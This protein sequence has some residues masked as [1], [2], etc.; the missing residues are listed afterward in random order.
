LAFLS[1]FLSFLLFFFLVVC[2]SRKK[3]ERLTMNN[4]NKNVYRLTTRHGDQA[5]SMASWLVTEKF[6]QLRKTTKEKK[7]VINYKELDLLHFPLHF[8]LLHFSHR[9]PWMDSLHSSDVARILHGTP[10]CLA[11]CNPKLQLIYR[12]SILFNFSTY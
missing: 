1:F 6:R 7:G 8:S 12:I 10:R 2:S 9:L 11:D 3:R 5:F 4:N